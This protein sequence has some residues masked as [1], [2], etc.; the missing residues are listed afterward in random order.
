MNRALKIRE[1]RRKRGSR[2]QLIHP[3][4]DRHIQYIYCRT[5]V[6]APKRYPEAFV[7]SVIKLGREVQKTSAEEKGKFVRFRRKDKNNVNHFFFST[8]WLGFV[9]AESFSWN[10][11][12]FVSRQRPWSK[13][14]ILLGIIILRLQSTIPRGPCSRKKKLSLDFARSAK[15]PAHI[16]VLK[17]ELSGIFLTSYLLL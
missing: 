16:P 8:P 17:I 14:G 4:S 5:Y 7:E 3:I 9:C 11:Y 10:L 1:R 12:L 2:Y 6:C 13:L 15:K